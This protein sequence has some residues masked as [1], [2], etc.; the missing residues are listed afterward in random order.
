MRR[1]EAVP[2]ELVPRSDVQ[3]TD[4]AAVQKVVAKQEPYAVPVPEETKKRAARH[5]N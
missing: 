5:G 1:F 3:S 4:P 2:L